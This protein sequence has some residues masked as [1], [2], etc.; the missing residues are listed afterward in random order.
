MEGK[1]GLTPGRL[2]TFQVRWEGYRRTVLKC[3]DTYPIPVFFLKNVLSYDSALPS[4]IGICSTVRTRV[5]STSSPP[6]LGMHL[7]NTFMNSSLHGTI[8][9]YRAGAAAQRVFALMDSLP[10]IDL[11]KVLTLCNNRS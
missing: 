6:S 11:D 10:D 1:D 2:I 7:S 3:S 4:Y 9:V 8:H 5:C